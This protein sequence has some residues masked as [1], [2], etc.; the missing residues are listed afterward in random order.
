[1]YI[2]KRFDKKDFVKKYRKKE[3]IQ[4]MSYAFNFLDKN[5]VIKYTNNYDIVLRITHFEQP[6]CMSDGI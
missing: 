4:Q 5:H 6:V 2:V 3:G 1:M